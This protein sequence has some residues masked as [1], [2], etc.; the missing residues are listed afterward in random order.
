MS[1][2]QRGCSGF[3]LDTLDE[4]IEFLLGNIVS[5]FELG[6][7]LLEGGNPIS[8]HVGQKRGFGSLVSEND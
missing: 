4:E 1:G 2:D 5:A 6:N 3:L 7:G 8:L